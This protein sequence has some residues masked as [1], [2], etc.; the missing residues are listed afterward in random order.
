MTYDH[1]TEVGGAP[2]MSKL[3]T[4]NTP[5]PAVIGPLAVLVITIFNTTR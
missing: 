2:P 5:L 3:Q 4:S 1:I